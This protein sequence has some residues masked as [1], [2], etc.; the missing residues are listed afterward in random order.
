[1]EIKIHQIYYDKKTKEDIDPAFIPLNNEN[2]MG[3]EWY[4]FLPILKYFKENKPHKDI[5]YGFLSPKFKAK[6]GLDG[7]E[8]T[9]IIKEN[10]QRASVLLASPEWDQ[11]AYFKNT[12]EQGDFY[13]SGLSN[14][15]KIFLS[16]NQINIDIDHIVNDSSNA[17][18]S[19]YIIAKGDYWKD[20][21]RLADSFY[22]FSQ[23][24][25]DMQ[26]L[27]KGKFY[28]DYPLK[29]FIQERFPS[30]LLY[31]NKYPTINIDMSKIA[32]INEFLFEN[33][34]LTRSKLIYCDQLKK[35]FNRTKKAKYYDEYLQV[36]KQIFFR[37]PKI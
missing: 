11:I 15:T 23:E 16:K 27:S 31:E 20:W 37:N 9:Q 29:V 3:K 35:E 2:M 33:N 8:I 12:F 13:H 7:K 30:L 34:E 36:K 21:L 28:K 19:N 25:A 10:D 24:K 22:K 18:F 26:K 17:V 32:P 5:W 1:M 4:E 6:T 14:L